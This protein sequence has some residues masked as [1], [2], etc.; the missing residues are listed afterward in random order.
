M[1]G[2][3]QQSKAELI[4]QQVEQNVLTPQEDNIADIED[5][6]P[7]AEE[8]TEEP[9]QLFDDEPVDEISPVDE[10]ARRIMICRINAYRNSERLSRHFTGTQLA[11]VQPEAL[12]HLS[13]EELRTLKRSLSE[14]I[15]HSRVNRYGI[16][17]FKTATKTV[18]ELAKVVGVMSHGYAAAMDPERIGNEEIAELVEEVVIDVNTFTYV[19]PWKRLAAMS[20]MGLI[21]VHNQNSDTIRML[22]A[23]AE[24]EMQAKAAAQQPSP[25]ALDGMTKLE[26]AQKK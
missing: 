10:K 2:H 25:K 13:L 24:R 11:Q 15:Q 16:K 9:E 1:D 3:D 5:E 19:E 17:A 7:A 20:A 26:Q 4:R 23:A 22:K 6:Q 8:P 18:E 12:E 14:T 21:A